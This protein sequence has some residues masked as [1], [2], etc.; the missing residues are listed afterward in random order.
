MKVPN[1]SVEWFRVIDLWRFVEAIEE[2]LEVD[3]K[4]N[5]RQNDVKAWMYDYDNLRERDIVVDEIEL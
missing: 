2:D 4:W 5:D 1:D 3:M